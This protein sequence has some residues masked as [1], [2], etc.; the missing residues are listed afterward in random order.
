MR[1]LKYE[2]NLSY[3]RASYL[4]AYQSP[5]GDLYLSLSDKSSIIDADTQIPNT[6]S[7]LAYRYFCTHRKGRDIFKS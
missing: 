7:A 2:I 6:K 5:M 4:R 1:G 3:K